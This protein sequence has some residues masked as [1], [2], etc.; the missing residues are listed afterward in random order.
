MR[1]RWVHRR[2]FI[3]DTEPHKV[4]DDW[5]VASL[6]N[7]FTLSYDPELEVARALDAEGRQWVVLGG[8]FD[9]D[10]GFCKAAV[11][12][13]RLP[14]HS[15]VDH[16]Y[17]WA[18]RWALVGPK[19]IIPD[20][21]GLLGLFH[22]CSCT[23]RVIISS[24]LSLITQVVKESALEPA[25]AV[26]PRVL[27]TH[28]MNW[29]PP[30]CTNVEPARKLLPDQML[31]L[32]D[33]R[34]LPLARVNPQKYAQISTTERAHL[35]F[36]YLV[37]LLKSLA[38]EQIPIVIALTAGL[39]TRCTLAAALRAGVRFETA[40]VDWKLISTADRQL[41]HEIAKR[42]AFTHTFVSRDGHAVH[43]DKRAVRQHAF[44]RFIDPEPW[45]AQRRIPT[46]PLNQAFLVH[47]NCWE[48]ARCFFYSRL[49]GLDLPKL[50][51][52]PRSLAGRYK[53]FGCIDLIARQLRKWASWRQE[54]ADGYDWRDIF[55][56]DQ[57][58]CG[59][60]SM[61]EQIQDMMDCR[62]VQLINSCKIFDIFLSQEESLRKNAAVQH[63]LLRLSETG[64]ER[65]PINPPEEFA[66][67]HLL[68][69]RKRSE[70]LATESANLV[71]RFSHKGP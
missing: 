60:L 70:G 3:L 67:T 8:A 56:R 6:Q 17:S 23:A 30:P 11:S 25:L 47:S 14:T 65:F 44:Y 7:G 2:Q 48:L 28:G 53:N 68:R 24:S 32:D 15:V 20:A 50:V 35:V 57:R 38:S 21:S 26:A 66:R 16:T 41:P 54:H 13:S 51:E 27:S 18:G 63:E 22:Y 39:D 34:A 37:G 19:I 62:S 59:W 12:I 9:L 36:G 33:G 46:T 29:V 64:L 1:C 40:T 45:T 52:E 10:N 43:L 49:A 5:L 55:Y 4:R 58:L 31:S 61:A 69:W 71:L 42:Y